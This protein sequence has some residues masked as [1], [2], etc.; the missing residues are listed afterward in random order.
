MPN[1]EIETDDDESEDGE[2]EATPQF[3]PL[4]ANVGRPPKRPARKGPPVAPASP[5]FGTVNRNGAPTAIEGAGWSNKEADLMWPEMLQRIE[6]RGQSPFEIIAQVVPYRE[7][8]PPIG[9]IEGSSIVGDASICP[10][11]ALIAAVDRFHMATTEGAQLYEIRFLWKASGQVYGRGKLGRP[12]RAQIIAARMA[13]PQQ[14]GAPPAPPQGYPP[15]PSPGQNWPAQPPGY[16]YPPPGL[17]APWWSAPPSYYPP[18][19]APAAPQGPSEEV[20]QLREELRRA[21]EREQF[22]RG[23]VEEVA[24][25]AREGRTPN[26]APPPAAPPPPPA[27]AVAPTSTPSMA[28]EEIVRRVTSEVV[29]LLGGRAGLGAAPPAA[30]SVESQMNRAVSEMMSGLLNSFIKKTGDA[31]QQSFHPVGRSRRRNAR[32]G[33]SRP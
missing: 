10:S 15:P 24:R 23:T 14:A 33:R 3:A 17:G 1:E 30:N 9:S 32:A 21:A 6:K 8:S 19:Q 7:G 28:I 12:P 22:Y 29:T 25:A 26:I 31:M 18:P 4:P 2:S 16:G 13:Q 20:A 5:G 11:E 27:A